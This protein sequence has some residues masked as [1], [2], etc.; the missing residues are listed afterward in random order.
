MGGASQGAFGRAVRQGTRLARFGFLKRAAR[1]DERR[2]PAG[3]LWAQVTDP[4][5]QERPQAL[6]LGDLAQLQFGHGV[7]G[8]L[9][10]FRLVEGDQLPVDVLELGD[11]RVERTDVGGVERRQDDVDA[12]GDV[13]PA[14]VC[15]PRHTCQG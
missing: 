9:G 7:L 4:R 6:E 15:G 5:L 14:N 13:H 8:A 11:D 2:P 12:C 3:P 10:Q 1:G